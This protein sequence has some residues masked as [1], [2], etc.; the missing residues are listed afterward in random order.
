VK[1]GIIGGGL[2]AALGAVV[3]AGVLVAGHGSP[4]GWIG[5]QYTR[6]AAGEYR[7]SAS[8]ARVASAIGRKFRPSDRAI[9]G[10]G[11]FLRYPKVVVA[12]LGSGAGSRIVVD[13]ADRGYRRWYSHVGS[14]WR[15]PTSRGSVFR[16]GGPGSGK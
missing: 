12:V 16:G 3:L 1:R 8:P 9:D 2:L 13:D 4:R 15:A 10:S 6:T 5:K 11:I 7:S 14:R